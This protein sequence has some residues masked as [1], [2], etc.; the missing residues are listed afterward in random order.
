M[1]VTFYFNDH[2]IG[3][4]HLLIYFKAANVL[5]KCI[6]TCKC[7]IYTLFI[8]LLI[9]HFKVKMTQIYTHV[10]VNGTD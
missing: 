10:S 6:H 8:N 9:L 3:I 1:V 5:Q 7:H 2:K 4:Q